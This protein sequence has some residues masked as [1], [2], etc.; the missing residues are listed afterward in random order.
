[1]FATL[2]DAQ[3]SHLAFGPDGNLYVSEFFG[4][5]VRVYDAHAGA[6]FG[7]RLADAATALSSAGGLAFMP[8]GDL[9]VGDGFGESARIARFSPGA[10]NSPTTF[11]ITDMGVLSSPVSLL[12]LPSGDL[13]AVDLLGN[14]IARF[15]STGM[16]FQPF[17][18]V[19]PAIPEP[20]WPVGANIPSNSPSGIAFDPD[21]NVILSV[22]GFT[23]P[24]GENSG[25]LI[26]YD[27]TGNIIDPDNDMTP[28]E[29]IASGLEPIGGIAWTPSLK[30]LAGDYDGDNTVGPADYAK[31][32]ADFGNFVAP[33][34]GADGNV[35]GIV[36]AA[37]FVLWRNA[38]SS[39]VGTVAAVPEP[40]ALL[41]MLGGLSAAAT[42]RCRRKE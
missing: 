39:G 40:T 20:P 12:F 27:L 4:T 29:P 22:L 15:D 26:R 33:G 31:W 2:Q 3:P 7:Q 1:L 37:D 19:P 35:N 5:N 38:S 17:A 32:R 6:S 11:G 36:D 28:N 21:G 42:L 30:T 23:G 25:T 10:P 24:P 8:N 16:N 18:L 34:N 13:L 14:Y 41:L 9:L